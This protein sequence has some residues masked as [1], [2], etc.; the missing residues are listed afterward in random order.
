MSSGNVVNISKSMIAAII[1]E[2]GASMAPAHAQNIISAQKSNGISADQFF[3]N[4]KSSQNVPQRDGN[5]VISFDAARIYLYFSPEPY[6]SLE[7]TKKNYRA[8]IC[9]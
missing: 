1:K 8:A 2:L 5:P 3:N 6:L 4:M 9:W 7:N